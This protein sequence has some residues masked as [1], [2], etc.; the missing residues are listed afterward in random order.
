MFCSRNAYCSSLISTN[1][2][3]LFLMMVFCFIKASFRSVTSLKRF[4]RVVS[5]LSLSSDSTRVDRRVATRVLG[6]F[7][8]SR[9]FALGRILLFLLGA[10]AR[11][12]GG[13]V[14]DACPGLTVMVDIGFRAQPALRQ[15]V[16]NP[17]CRAPLRLLHAFGV[18]LAKV[19]MAL[20]S[21][22]SY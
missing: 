7:W 22:C 16:P 15:R 3:W 9:A 2:A 18:C 4:Q 8:A 13:E 12:A 6:V 17:G 21:Q 1:S 19:S 5:S 10:R 11:R 20:K 14:S